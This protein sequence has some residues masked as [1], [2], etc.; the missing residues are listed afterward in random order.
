MR[1][2]IPQFLCFRY[3]GLKRPA[4]VLADATKLGWSFRKWQNWKQ[5]HVSP[6]DKQLLKSLGD[7]LVDH[8]RFDLMHFG[9]VSQ[10]LLN[11]QR[12]RKDRENLAVEPDPL[13]AWIEC[14]RLLVVADENPNVILQQ[15]HRDLAG[16]NSIPAADLVDIFAW[17]NLA[18]FFSKLKQPDISLSG[19]WAPWD[20]ALLA[21]QVRSAIAKLY[22]SVGLTVPKLSSVRGLTAKCMCDL[23][24]PA[25]NHQAA[26]EPTSLPPEPHHKLPIIKYTSQGPLSLLQ[27][28]NVEGHVYVAINRDHAFV[29]GI[30]E[31]NPKDALEMILTAYAEAATELLRKENDFEQLSLRMGVGLKRLIA[32][33]R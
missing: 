13:P 32:S 10:I 28:S 24:F 21:E 25:V 6:E 16:A 26:L 7:Q 17:H 22:V 12:W 27:V 23:G 2:T 15:L 14:E 31:M 18:L 4:E 3:K 33:K 20:F 5:V 1:E 30:S 8:Q 11:V 19:F 9:R 29:K